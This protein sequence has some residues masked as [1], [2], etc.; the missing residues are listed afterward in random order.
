M[1]RG[2]EYLTENSSFLKSEG[3]KILFERLCK[4]DL[5]ENCINNLLYLMPA[6]TNLCILP[7]NRKKIITNNN[8]TR[9][10]EVLIPYKIIALDLSEM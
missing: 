8:L 1:V 10:L 7:Q 4:F 6:F 3:M 9:I 5:Y 2:C